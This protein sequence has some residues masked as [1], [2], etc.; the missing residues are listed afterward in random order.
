MAA[1]TILAAVAAIVG[2]A[3]SLHAPVDGFL[4]PIADMYAANADLVPPREVTDAADC[5]ADCTTM[6]DCVS[7]N[8]CTNGSALVCGV[9]GWSMAYVP[10]SASTCS[11]YRRVV[12]RNDAPIS[13]AVPW[14]VHTPTRDVDIASGPL[15]DAFTG[16]VDT[17]LRVRDPLD[18]LFFFAKRA[19][20]TNPPGQC[21][22]W[23]EWIKGSAAGNFLMGTGRSLQW[24]DD[25]LL[26][27]NAQTVVDGIKEYAEVSVVR[28]GVA[29]FDPLRAVTGRWQCG[30]RCPGGWLVWC[31]TTAG[32]G[33]SMK[34]TSGR[35]TCPTTVHRG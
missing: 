35:T 19:G 8:L 1:W 15:H 21:F 34:A 11:W 33:R 25:P 22:G 26:R 17:Y 16:N 14:Q 4:P 7:F 20:V 27:A 2:A 12:P 32:C 10:T 3:P 18:M 5:A 13:Q 29:V 9:S 24:V 23:D 31:R 30:R 6:P 28:R